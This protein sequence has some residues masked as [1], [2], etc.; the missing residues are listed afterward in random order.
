VVAGGCTVAGHA[1]VPPV[2]RADP[3][4]EA[5]HT[6]VVSTHPVAEH[7]SVPMTLE[8]AAPHS[9]PSPGARVRLELKLTRRGGWPGDLVLRA[10]VPPG[11]TLVE[12]RALEPIPDTG[13]G[14]IIRTLELQLGPSIPAQDLL[15][16]AKLS[17]DGFGVTSRAYYRFGRPEPKL[18]RGDGRAVLGPPAGAMRSNQTPNDAHIQP[19][20]AVPTFPLPPQMP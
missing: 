5:P 12:S 6:D 4:D 19:P 15:V 17:G 11:A 3:A 10:D 14:E 18:Q 16:T 13:P 20:V 1:P 2:V 7:V 8:L 9:A